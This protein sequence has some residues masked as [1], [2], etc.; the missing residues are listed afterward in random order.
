MR[1]DDH[2]HALQ[3]IKISDKTGSVLYFVAAACCRLYDAV[4]GNWVA[5]SNIQTRRQQAAAL[6]SAFGGIR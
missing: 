1:I 4:N 3:H 5:K 2:A 6:Q